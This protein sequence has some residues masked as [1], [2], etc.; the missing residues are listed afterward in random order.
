MKQ[1]LLILPGWGGTNE[2]WNDFIKI[3]KKKYEVVCLNLPCFGDEPCPDC[4]WGVEDYAKFVKNK[5]QELNFKKPILFGHSFG[6]QIAVYFAAY[7]PELICKLILSG[8]A[9]IR[10]NNTIRRIVLG[11]FAKF[12]KIVLKLPIIEKFDILIKRK[13]YCVFNSSDYAQTSGI[14]RDIFK[15]IIRQDLTHLLP[16]INLSTLIIW[17]SCDRY[18][19]L[20]DG[21]KIAKLIPNAKLKIIK[22]GKHGLHIQQPENLLKAIN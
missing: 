22:N 19:P 11:F 5:I 2:T 20:S 13:L 14:K 8:A 1:K 6:G 9:V 18:T 16:K 15:K 4:V 17:G 3:A 12:G 10:H 21:K 7:Y